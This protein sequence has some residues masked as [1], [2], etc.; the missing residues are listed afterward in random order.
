MS[1]VGFDDGTQQQRVIRAHEGL[2]DDAS[3]C[4]MQERA[5]S[6]IHADLT[7]GVE[8][9]QAKRFP[10]NAGISFEGVKPAG[11]FDRL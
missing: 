6:A 7:S 10:E 3:K 8:V 2:E 4:T 9:R 11:K 5:V 1:I